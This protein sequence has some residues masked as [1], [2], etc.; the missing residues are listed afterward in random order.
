MRINIVF[1]YFLLFMTSG[2]MTQPAAPIQYNHDKDFSNKA[3]NTVNS[4][5]TS[6]DS[7]YANDESEI[8]R[9]EIS[10]KEEEL[11]Q[12]TGY[13]V[14]KPKKEIQKEEDLAKEEDTIVVPHAK[15]DPKQELPKQ[16]KE[17]SLF[18]KPLE[19]KIIT[20]FGQQTPIGRNNGINIAAPIGTS[21][22]SIDAGAVVYTGKDARF[23]NLIIIKLE[24][25]DLY[26][27][28]A[29]LQDILVKKGSLVSQGEVIGHVGQT[30]N[31]Q[32]PQLHFAIREGKLAVDPLK[33]LPNL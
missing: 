5:K 12:P 28:Y 3:N 9:H 29:H 31:V 1:F 4:H 2:C 10:V 33:Y 21:V 8:I 26:V 11:A 17:G 20:K 30:G 6:N 27:A 19:G 14:E 13:L 24:D 16:S 25:K 15:L 32:S 7:K 22:E 23:G 18:I